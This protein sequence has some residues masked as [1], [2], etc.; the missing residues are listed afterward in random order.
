MTGNKHGTYGRT[1]ETDNGLTEHVT[2]RTQAG[3]R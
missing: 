2:R 3:D 1:H